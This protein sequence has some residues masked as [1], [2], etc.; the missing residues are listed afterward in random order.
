MVASDTE[1]GVGEAQPDGDV[2]AIEAGPR[3]PGADEGL[4]ED[5]VDADEEENLTGIEYGVGV[6]EGDIVEGELAEES[7]EDAGGKEA[8]PRLPGAVE[9]LGD[10]G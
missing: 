3:L 1:A 4:D 8:E 2:D 7:D 5:G 9:G 10:D 6:A